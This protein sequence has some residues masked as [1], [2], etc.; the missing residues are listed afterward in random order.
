MTTLA[1]HL[2][3]LD[4]KKILLVE[5]DAAG[6]N[7]IYLA[8]APYYTEPGDTPGNQN[9]WP[10]IAQDGVPR[11]ARRIQEIFG[12]RSVPAWGPLVVATPVVG[13]T[14]LATTA[15]RGREARVLLTGPRSVI[16]HADAAVVLTGLI[17][18]RTGDIDGGVVL[19]ITDRQAAWESVELPAARYNGTETGNFP[20]AEIGRPKPLCL[21]RCRNITPRLINTATR[22]YQVNNGSVQA[23]DAVYDNGVSV[24]FTAN[25]AAGT[26]TLT[27]APTGVVTADVRGMLDGVTWL[28]STT[29]IIDWLARTYGGLSAGSIDIS[30][31]PSDEI[32]IYLDEPT[33]LADI[34]TRLMQAI[35]GWW[36]FTRI[37]DLR[38]RIFDVPAS[39]GP[40]FG[41]EHHLSNVSWEED[42]DIVW[43][44]PLLY[45]RNWTRIEQPAASVSLNQTIWLRGEGYEARQENA[46]ILTQYPD[47][48]ST[49]RLMT[50]FDTLAPAQ[51][52][53]QRALTLF[54]TL[55]R[56]ARTALPY[57]DPPVE[58]G[59]SLTLDDVGLL[60]GDR[61]LMAIEERWDGEIPLVEV[62]LWG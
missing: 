20:S 39:G 21:G 61:V 15:L 7:P 4:S 58:L 51:A 27:N 17:G 31:L 9:Y 40:V 55:R 48:L 53:A 59:D 44:V 54:G 29:Q 35:L 49:D 6:S 11:L 12:G 18:Y 34:I 22:V 47:A 2:A 37:G 38:A 41:H 33:N 10:V 1:E 14:D 25:T 26:F 30:G 19:E 5:I 28:S 3:R 16:P 57:I 45:R 32:G 24:A 60:N 42:P 52:V 46:A 8:D 62:E 36:G 50:Y 13:V 56:R 23:I 43:S